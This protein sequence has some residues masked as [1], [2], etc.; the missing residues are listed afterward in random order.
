MSFRL[1]DKFVYFNNNHYLKQLFNYLRKEE[2]WINRSIIHAII[3]E[4]IIMRILTTWTFLVISIH[5]LAQSAQKGFQLIEQQNYSSSIDVF[6]KSI[7]KNKD[8]LASKFGLALIYSNTN[9]PKFRYD[10]AYRNLVYSE[11]QYGKITGSEKSILKKDFNIDDISIGMLKRKILEEALIEAKKIG[12][13]EALTNFYEDFPFTEQSKEAKLLIN[14]L[15]LVEVTKQNNP[16][17]LAEFIR[18]NPGTPE[19]DSA[20]LLMDKLETTTY[21]YYSYEGELESLLEF[22]KIYPNY[23]DKDRFQKDIAL[24]DYA[25]K[26]NMDETYNRNMESVYID[27]LKKAAP[28]ELA[29]VAL[30]RTITPFL[31]E[32]KWQSAIDQLEKYKSYFPQDIRIDKIINILKATD[33]TLALESLSAR[34]NSG[35]HEYAPVFTA[36]GRSLFFCGR[37]RKGNIGGEDIFISRF[38]DNEWTKPELLSSINTPYAHEAPL[39]ISADGSRLLIYAN[40][41][42]YYSD[43]TANGWSIPLPFPSVNQQNSWE[44]DAFITSDGNAI[45]F[46]SDR[47]GNHGNL[48]KFGELFHGSHSGNS[49]IYVSTRTNDGWSKPVNLGRTINTPY[50]ERSPF[51]HPDMKT[52]YFSSDGHAGLGRLDVFKSVRL[53]DSTWTEWSEPLNLGKEINSYGDEYDYKIS[54]DGKFAYLSSLDSGNYD[55]KKLEIPVSIRPEYVATVWGTISNRKGEPIQTAIRWEDLKDGKPIGLLQSDLISGNY[56]IILPL[57]KNYGYFIEDS[58][59]Y[60]LSGNIDLTN[61]KEEM[62]IRKDFVLFSNSEII[63][64][65]IAVPL[66]NVFFE[67]NQYKLKPES[68]SELNRLIKFLKKN[69]EMKIEIAGHTDNIGTPEYNKKLSQQRA[70]SVKEYLLKNGIESQKLVSEGYGQTKPIQTNETVEGRAKNRRVEFKVILK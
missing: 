60:P 3:Y 64:E 39:A 14:K 17:V 5:F 51:L 26:I 38:I 1:F 33:L 18:K 7:E 6:N 31:I 70:N 41:D 32:K 45:L 57:G 42:I 52:L 34:I 13:I 9:F 49:D 19:A 15:K 68:F 8:V 59:Y 55:I 10:R 58:N 25:F 53:N 66:E 40:T 43:K 62:N 37:G 36:D 11:K 61:E 63:N 47:G 28:V 35:G 24:A 23:K 44:A 54:T 12:T 2:Y 16:S 65:G 50:S 21:Q 22:Q 48:H 4:I 29:F 27:Y 30:I 20:Q 69:P 67:H 56:L 46:I